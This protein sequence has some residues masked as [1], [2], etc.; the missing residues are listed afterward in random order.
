[1]KRTMYLA[2]IAAA[3]GVLALATACGGDDD[4]GEPTVAA[5]VTIDPAAAVTPFPTGVVTG[6]A[7]VAET[8]GYSATFP[9][10]WRP[11]F[12]FI[13]TIDSS[14]DAYFE[15]QAPDT[16]VQAS[17]VVECVLQRVG[18]PDERIALEKTAI[19]RVGLNEDIVVSERQISGMTATVVSYIN[20]SQQ[21]EQP[22][23]S[24][25]DLLFTGE[26]CDY[27]ITTTAA[28]GER[29]QYEA[30]FNTFLDSFELLR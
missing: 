19:A 15:P 4:N 30:D 3:I 22:E 25:Q 13:N 20:T 27:T 17:I 8:K 5:T 29:E 21:G 24:K 11:R 1:M 16:E 10:G 9:D 7:V 28:A 6:N 2:A 26:V 14:V 18:T 12:N 23:L